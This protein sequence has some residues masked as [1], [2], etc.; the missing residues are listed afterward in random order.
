MKP[1]T[2]MR[3]LIVLLAAL[4]GLCFSGCSGQG[5]PIKIGVIAELTGE[6]SAVGASCRNAARMAADEINEGGGLLINDKRH[7][8]ELIIED[9]GGR[10]DLSEKA[11][12]KL[13]EKDKVLAIVGP[14]ASRFVIAAAK[15][16]ERS[17][18]LLIS[19]WSTSPKAT[20]DEAGK[21]LKYVFRACWIDS[22]QGSVIAKFVLQTLGLKR[23]A[24]LYD[25]DS[26]Y[27][28]GIANFFR[29]AFE[30]GGGAVVA[31]EAYKAGQTEFADHLRKIKAA[32]P[33]IVFLPNYYQEM[34]LQVKQAK[35]MGIRVPFIGSDSWGSHELLEKCPRD[36]DKFYFSSHFAMDAPAA[37]TR[38]FINN[39]QSRYNR[40]PDDV[41]ALTYDAFGMLWQALKL[42]G[43]PDREMIRNAMA[44]IP[45]YNGITGAMQFKEGSGDPVKSAVMLQIRDGQFTW[46]MNAD[47]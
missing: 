15:S 12:R 14:N 37:A 33:D 1:I 16:A 29:E 32:G 41:A 34:P 8:V 39:Y 46:F 19:P 20:I 17:E 9:N 11:V 40:I 47:P 45:R 38:K 21:P 42:A 10:E 44:R 23:A 4:P 3:I 24:V 2:S 22:F 25:G 18:V 5:E 6:L 31:Y 36:C 35:Q 28:R 30:K 43:K 26:E 13:V 27:N 7:R